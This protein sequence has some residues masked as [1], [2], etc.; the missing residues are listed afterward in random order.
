MV[1][2]ANKWS[3]IDERCREVRSEGHNADR[4]SGWRKAELDA[5][6]TKVVVEIFEC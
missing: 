3:T 5:E 4:N 1:S 2:K 6:D